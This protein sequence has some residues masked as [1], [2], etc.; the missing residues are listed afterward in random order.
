MKLNAKE[1]IKQISM[2]DKARL[3]SGKNFWE[4]ESVLDLPNIMV[5]DGPHG[6]RKQTESPDHIGLS[7]SVKS[8]CY[9]TAVGLAS[10]WDNDL[11]YQVGEHLGEE[12]RTE[13]VSV[14]LGPGINIKRHPLCGRN[15]EYFSEDPYL[16]GHLATNFIKGVQSKGIGTS[17]KHFV[18]NNQETMRMA[19]D[20]IVDERTLREI[21][22]KGFEIAVKEAQPWT[23][24]CSYN[25]V[26]G[27][28]LSENKHFLQDILK[29]EWQHKGIVVTDWG[30]CNNRV[31]G[32]NAGQELEMPG[33]TEHN[34]NL[35]IKAIKN[36][37][38]SID[39]L[40]SRVERVIDLILKSLPVLNTTYEPYNKENHHQFAR[41]VAADSIVLLKNEK[42][43]LPLQKSQSIALIGEF[44]VKPRF[45]GSGSSLINPTK[46]ATALDA[47]KEVLGDNV[48]YAQGYNSK[49]DVIE[50]E[51]ID[52]SI[53]L[54]K[55]KDVVV[56]M[57]G[58]TDS[59]ESEGFDRTHLN[60]PNNH[61]KLIEEIAKVNENIVVCLSNG[62]PIEMQ[63]QKSAKAI[64]EQYLG[65]QASGE[66][67]V[68][69]LYGKVNPSG[70]L[71]ETFPSSLAEFP[72]NQN[73][74]GLPR[75]VEY[76]EGL[77]VGYR[78]Y[79]TAQVN[80]LYSFGYGLSY[81][82][83]EYS[84]LKVD[85]KKDIVIQFDITNTGNVEGK[86]VCQI[87]VSKAMSSVYR[88][89]QELKGYQKVSL[90][91]GE[92]KTVKIITSKNDLQV[93][94]DGFKIEAGEY[95]LKVGSSSRDI[96]LSKK[97]KIKGLKLQEDNFADY[98]NISRG[99]SPSK[100]AFEE[101]YGCKIPDYPSKRPFTMNSVIG[102]IQETFVGNKI[103]KMISER[104][105]E[106]V[107]DD[108]DESMITMIEHMA[109]ELPLRSLVMLSAGEVSM[110]RAQ[111]LLDL[112]NK[113]ILRGLIKVI[114]G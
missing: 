25:K 47:F 41:K 22:L 8:T 89:L 23:V 10:T 34:T 30:A 91:P 105:S 108:V 27:T 46:I 88:P 93:Y 43:I 11:L 97:I 96:H 67:L 101:V 80:P 38:L 12:S 44:A 107:T 60:I 81:T 106:L 45:Q 100:E 24:M 109:D 6:L 110:R 40:D 76:R 16:S 68:D 14:L 86:E 56:L 39:V 84:N 9:P 66:A 64:V 31:D 29:D 52:K 59:F 98:K 79:D 5:T 102:E 54:A 104:F 32:L 53:L 4:L 69:I 13:K 103:K 35:I 19:V 78:Y 42:S 36:E 99:F 37:T 73:F 18:A 111:G 85:N 33:G 114:K 92:T 57:I 48:G 7:E 51:L 26:N 21:Y 112:M 87:Y 75:Q 77:Y 74:P 62:S 65:G 113:K 3:C 71:A 55:S 2:E 28:Y 63:W 83:F 70:K 61:L 72:S 94:Q 20:T 17:I 50:Q 95:E 1:I 90:E 15:F 82:T 58:L 49:K